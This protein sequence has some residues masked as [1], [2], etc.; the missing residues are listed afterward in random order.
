LLKPHIGPVEFPDLAPVGPG[1][2][3]T[4]S[5]F[6]EHRPFD[7]EHRVG[8]EGV[9]TGTVVALDSLHQADHTHVNQVIDLYVRREMDRYPVHDSFHMGQIFLYQLVPRKQIVLS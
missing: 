6:T 3:I 8:Q 9:V 1:Q 7:S 2:K 4:G 5:Q